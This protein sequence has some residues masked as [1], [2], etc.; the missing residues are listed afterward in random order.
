MVAVRLA[1]AAVGLYASKS[2]IGAKRV[3]IR[4]LADVRDWSLFTYTAPFQ[5]LQNAK[6]FQ[7]ILGSG[8]IALQNNSTR[9]LLSSPGR[10]RHRRAPAFRRTR[11]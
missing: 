1:R 3:R 10:R 6:W 2:L 8:S 4:N 11:A 7:P 5:V 9:A